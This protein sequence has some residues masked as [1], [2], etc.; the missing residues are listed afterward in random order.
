MT[1]ETTA[2]PTTAHLAKI[3]AWMQRLADET[4]Q[5]AQSAELT[6]YLT[7]LTAYPESRRAWRSLR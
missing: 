1:T 4:D 3:D 6:R 2:N 7:T 5:A